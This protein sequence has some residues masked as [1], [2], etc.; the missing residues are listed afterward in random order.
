MDDLSFFREIWRIDSPILLEKVEYFKYA[1]KFEIICWPPLLC[2][3]E[4]LVLL[5]LTTIIILEN[6]VKVID[7]SFSSE[8]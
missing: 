4:F 8:L 6:D 3:T 2:E 5:L 1:I 7:L